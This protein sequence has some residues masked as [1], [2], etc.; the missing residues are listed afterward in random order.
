MR[1]ARRL[2]LGSGGMPAS[3]SYTLTSGVRTHQ[4]LVSA[5]TLSGYTISG[6]TPSWSITAK[7]AGS[8]ATIS[9]G[10]T[11]TAPV[12]TPDLGGEYELTDATSGARVPV[13]VRGWVEVFALDGDSAIEKAASPVTDLSVAGTDYTSD[14]T[15]F[16]VQITGSPTNDQVAGGM[17]GSTA[18]TEVYAIQ[19]LPDDLPGGVDTSTP[20]AA[21]LWFETTSPTLNEDGEYYGVLYRNA[22]ALDR[23]WAAVHNN[24]GTVEWRTDTLGAAGVVNAITTPYTS[25]DKGHGLIREGETCFRQY[26][27]TGAATDAPSAWTEDAGPFQP[28]V[29]DA[30]DSSPWIFATDYFR[31]HLHRAQAGSGTSW[32]GARI[33]IWAYL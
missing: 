20:I 31:F 1:R 10:A 11:T 7:P 29:V 23:V 32:A 16:E 19:V 25:P 14:G 8:S 9:S 22:S 21:G 17:D 18:A 12:F 13:I 27:W 26:S 4:S 15:A 28:R 3:V 2:G 30:N 6:G 5:F 33:F 24:S